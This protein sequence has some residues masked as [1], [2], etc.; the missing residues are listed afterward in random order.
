M[1]LPL[2]LA[3]AAMAATALSATPPTL[4]RLWET[5]ATLKV[6]EGVLLDEDRKVLYVSNID[7]TEPWG[8]DGAGSIARVTLDGQVQDAEWISGLHAPKGLGR[9]GHRL[10]VTDIDQLVIID[11]VNARIVERVAVPG[12]QRLNDV[13]TDPA[14]AVYFTDSQ[15]GHVYRWQDGA[16]SLFSQAFQSP[17]GILHAD[18]ALYVLD[19]ETLH[20][21]RPDGTLETVTQGL[22]GHVDGVVQDGPGFLVTCWEGLIYHAAHGQ[23]AQLLLDT[24]E[25]K[26]NAADPGWDAKRR[27]LYIPTFWKNTVVAYQLR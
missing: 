19:R 20:Q 16:V 8:K 21:L 27:I 26:A 22:K 6:P 11:L 25:A 15:T 17:N 24:R 14:G 18:G 9:I 13:T 7:G 1:K 5:P 2:A 12:A 23:P 3:A 4:V 10:F